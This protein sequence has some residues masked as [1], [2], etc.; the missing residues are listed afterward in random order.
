MFVDEAVR[1]TKNKNH[2]NEKDNKKFLRSLTSW[3][4]LVILE[5]IP[6]PSKEGEDCSFKVE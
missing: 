6:K 5:A 2:E 4:M 3:K 1:L